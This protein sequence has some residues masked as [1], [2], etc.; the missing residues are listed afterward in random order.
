MTPLLLQK[1]LVEDIKNILGN[2]RFCSPNGSSEINIYPQNLPLRN[3]KDEKELV[4]YCIVRVL[5]GTIK[6]ES[7]QEIK[8]YLIFG[9]YDDNKEQQGQETI[10]NIIQK[11]LE[12]FSKN[13]VLDQNFLFSGMFHWALE[14]EDQYPYYF[15]GIEMT[16]IAPG[17]EREDE[18]C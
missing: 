10:L 2:M 18:F 16:W 4:P 17:Y 11:I 14:D 3:R 13:P 5:E 15:G 8:V 7:K 12:R 6:E 9:I 1:A